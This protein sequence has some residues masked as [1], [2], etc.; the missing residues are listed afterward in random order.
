MLRYNHAPFSDITSWFEHNLRRLPQSTVQTACN[1]SA[2]AT[3]TES[4]YHALHR[5]T[6]R[7]NYF[8]TLTAIGKLHTKLGS[9]SRQGWDPAK[10]LSS[11]SGYIQDGDGTMT[12]FADGVNNSEETAI[13]K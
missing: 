8:A 1:L 11:I 2:T 10:L 13:F 7:P 3:I 4:Y 9:G 6:E 12:N 5:S